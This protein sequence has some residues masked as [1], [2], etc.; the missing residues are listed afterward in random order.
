MSAS[1]PF[2]SVFVASLL[3]SCVSSSSMSEWR[4]PGG[5]K[6]MHSVLEGAFF[7]VYFCVI[8]VP[9]T[10]KGNDDVVCQAVK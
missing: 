5:G 1:S 3:S 8:S 9:I 6:K 7:E 4:K 2:S 10:N